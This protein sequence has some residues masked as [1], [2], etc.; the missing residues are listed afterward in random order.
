MGLRDPFGNSIRILER[1]TTPA[2][3]TA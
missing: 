1:K 3:A 2:P